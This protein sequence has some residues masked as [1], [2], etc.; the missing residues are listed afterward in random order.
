MADKRSPEGVRKSGEYGMDDA[1][2]DYEQTAMIIR[3]PNF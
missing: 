2:T 1:T 3:N